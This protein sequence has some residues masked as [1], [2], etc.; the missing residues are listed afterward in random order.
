MFGLTLKRRYTQ[1]LAA[2]FEYDRFTVFDE[3]AQ[4]TQ[5]ALKLRVTSGLDL[6]KQPFK[7]VSLPMDPVV[8]AGSQPMICRLRRSTFKGDCSSVGSTCV[9]NSGT[10][11]LWATRFQCRP[12]ACAG[13]G[14]WQCTIRSA[15]DR[16][17]A[18]AE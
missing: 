12:M 10:M 5:Q 14:A 17:N 15:A 4:F 16:A 6:C 3:T 18:I 9:K 7:K 1:R 11:R 8:D 13:Y 2:Q